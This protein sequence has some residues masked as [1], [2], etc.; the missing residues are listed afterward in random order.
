MCVIYI[1]IKLGQG[2]VIWLKTVSSK[3]L[4]EATAPSAMGLP[5]TSQASCMPLALP[6]FLLPPFFPSFI[7]FYLSNFF[8]FMCSWYMVLCIRGF[9]GSSDGKASAYNVGD[10]GSIPGSEDPLEKETATRSSIHAWKIPWTEEPGQL[11]SMGSQRVGHWATSLH[12]IVFQVHS[13]VTSILFRFFSLLQD[14]EYSSWCYT[15]N[16]CC[17][18][19]CCMHEC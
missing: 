6:P 18:S 2:G 7:F 17:F 15:V 14:I 10:P 12:F 13:I 9:P 11:Q 1:W 4:L 3:F 16:P 5:G 8:S 19:I